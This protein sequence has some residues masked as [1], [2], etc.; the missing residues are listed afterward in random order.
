MSKITPFLMFVGQAAEAIALY[1]ALFPGARTLSLE[2][3]GPGE[4]GTPGS[5]KLAEIELA[6][7]RLMIFDSPVQHAFTFTPAVSLFVE[8][9]SEAEIDRLFAALSAGGAVLMPLQAYPFAARFAW[10][11]DRF[12]VSWQLRFGPGA[13]S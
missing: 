2:R 9:D 6:G 7:Q 3:Y 5:L 11:S 1:T 12:G 4:A 8:C 10:L 13:G